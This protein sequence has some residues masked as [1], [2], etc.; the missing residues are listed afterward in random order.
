MDKELNPIDR[1]CRNNKWVVTVVSN[2]NLICRDCIYRNDEKP[3]V[4]K[5]YQN[6]KPDTVFEKGECKEYIRV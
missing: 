6:I 2:D 4:C 5:M 1:K 3:G